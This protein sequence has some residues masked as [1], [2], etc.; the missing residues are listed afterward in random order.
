MRRNETLTTHAAMI[1]AS[2]Q[3][4]MYNPPILTF[5]LPT[6]SFVARMPRNGLLRSQWS[7]SKGEGIVGAIIYG[8]DAASRLSSDSMGA[9]MAAMCGVICSYR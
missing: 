6:L 1:S 8:D 7:Y 3:P 2:S 9:A 5:P 4:S